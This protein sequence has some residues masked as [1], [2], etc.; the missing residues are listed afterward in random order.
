MVIRPLDPCRDGSN[1]DRIVKLECNVDDCTGETLGYA[2]EQLFA[3]GARDVHYT[4]ILMKKNRP[5]YQITVICSP[6]DRDRM[7]DILFAQT[8]TIGIR[9]QLMERR[10]LPRESRQL[11]TSLGIVDVKVLFEGDRQR[12]VPE[13]ESIAAIARKKDLPFRQVYEQVLVE[14]PR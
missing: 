11:L 3:A 7:E 1:A 10:I 2:M 6:A 14:L 13:Y 8:T 12:F 5:A 9:A 4:P